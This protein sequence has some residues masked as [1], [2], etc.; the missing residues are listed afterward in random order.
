MKPLLLVLVYITEEHRALVAE[1]FDLIYAPNEGL[2]ADRSNGAAQIA[3]RGADIRVVLTNGTNGLL[4]S[5]IDA[6]PKLEIIC[7]L[8]VGFENVAIAHASARGIRVCN[9]ASTNDDCVADHAMGILLAAIRGIPALNLGV[10]QG[11]W[12]DDI[13]RPPH[14]SFRRMGILGLGAIGKKIAKR[15]IGF[16]MEIGYHGRTRRDD[17][18]YRFF[19]DVK[20]MATWCDFLVVA[21]PGGK[22]TFH[23]VN[24]DVLT[25]LGPRGVIVNISRGSLVDTQAVADALREGR[26]SAAALDVY[27]S[28]PRP[29]EALL[30][31]ANAV[32]TPHVAGISPEAIQASVQRFIDNATRHFAGLPLLTPVN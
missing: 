4:P 13:P 19:D 25:A 21:A 3:A 24:A 2:G 10:R 1:Q 23:I 14:V 18:G 20:S 26:I 16:D 22:D 8:G 28:E 27:E 6:M 9:A 12:R 15:A 5:E 32:L 30:E 11:K 17:T 31:F 7:T 29:P